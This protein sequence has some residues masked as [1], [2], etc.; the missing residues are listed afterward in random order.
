MGLPRSHAPQDRRS[1]ADASLASLISAIA[2]TGQVTPQDVLSLRRA[3]YADMAI[4]PAEAEAL[5]GLD[6][7]ARRRCV[8]W[9]DLFCEALTDYLVRQQQPEG[10][11]DD[12]KADWLIARLSADGRINSDSELAL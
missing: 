1:M 10:Y 8:E 2:A 11:I 4:A 5:I 3:I 6:E 12:A 9:N 7:A